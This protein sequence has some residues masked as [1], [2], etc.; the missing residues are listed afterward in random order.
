[1]ETSKKAYEQD[2]QVTGFGLATVKGQGAPIQYDG[3]EQGFVNTY[4]HIAY[5]LGYIVTDRKSVV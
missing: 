3:E 2:V 5:A 4:T 1:M